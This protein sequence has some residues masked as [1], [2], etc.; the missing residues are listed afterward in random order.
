MRHLTMLLVLVMGVA[1]GCSISSQ[2]TD[3]RGMKG[4]DGD[5]LTHINT[6]NYAIHLFMVKPLWGDATLQATVQS[7]ADEAKKAGANKIRIVQSDETTMWYLIPLLGFIFTPVT[8]IVA[9]DALLP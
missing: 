5:K 6:R 3:L 9:G 8:T 4:V 1:T 2:A 7:F